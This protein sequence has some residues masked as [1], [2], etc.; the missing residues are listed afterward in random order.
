MYRA[1]VKVDHTPAPVEVK[2]N[3]FS[4]NDA[5]FGVAAD[6]PTRRQKTTAA[7]DCNLFRRNA[8]SVTD[9]FGVRWRRFSTDTKLVNVTLTNTT[10]QGSWNRDSGRSRH[11]RDRRSRQTTCAEHQQLR[12]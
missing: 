9:P 7:V 4:G 10:F 11:H 6:E 2:R 8:P 12:P 5:D 1:G 3:V